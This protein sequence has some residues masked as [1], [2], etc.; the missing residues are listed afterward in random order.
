MNT[1]QTPL[2]AWALCVISAMLSASAALAADGKNLS[3]AEARYQKERA[4]CESGQS[5]QDRATCL[6]EAGAALSAAR[7]GA[8]GDGQVQYE[9]NALIRCERLPTD[10]RKACIDRMQGKGVIRGSAAEGGIYR[11]LREITLPDGTVITK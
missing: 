4:L 7:Q 2:R 3:E 11:E 10:E 9:Q 1:H 5:H 6:K 8:L